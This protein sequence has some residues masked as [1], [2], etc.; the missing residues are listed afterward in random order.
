MNK[1]GSV[2]FAAALLSTLVFLVSVSPSQ[3]GSAT[4]NL[5]A[6]TGDWNTAANWTPA[7]VL[8]RIYMPLRDTFL[9]LFVTLRHRAGRR[10]RPA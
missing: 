10:N 3:A 2:G 8:D 1:R 9:L 6:I 7:A 5:N 4:W